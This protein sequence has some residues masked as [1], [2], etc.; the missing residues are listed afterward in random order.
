MFNKKI[1]D[2]YEWA[3][4]IYSNVEAESLYNLFITIIY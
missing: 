4:Y 1:C 3:D 2:Q